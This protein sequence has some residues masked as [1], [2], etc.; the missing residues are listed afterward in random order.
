METTTL[1]PAKER[2]VRVV[3]D[4]HE[5]TKELL[6][7]V[8]SFD[9]PTTRDEEWKYTRVARITNETW[10][11]SHLVEQTD[12]QPFLIPGLDAYTIVFVNGR[13][14]A[15]LCKLPAEQGIHM[16]HES[17]LA[18]QRDSYNHFFQAYADA[19]CTDVVNVLVEK[20]ARI[21]KPIHFIH[22]VSKEQVL[23]QPRINLIAMQGAEV[24]C[25]E[26]FVGNTNTT[27]FTNRTLDIEVQENASVNWDKIQLEHDS[28][29]LMNEDNIRIAGD[30]RFTINTLTIDGGWVRNALNI[31]LDGQNIETN[32]NGFYMPRRKQF[33][34]NHTKVD[35]RHPHCNSNEL[36][37]GVLNDQ[38]TGVFNGKVYVQIDAQKTNAFQSCA[39]ILL[40]DDAQMNTK[41][42]LEIYADDVKCSHGTTTG[43]LDEEALFYLKSRGL[44]E[45]NARR[46]LTSAFIG[47]VISKIENETVREYVTTQL[48]QR[49]LLI[50]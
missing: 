30:G 7:I 45:D 13:Y 39:N 26:S 8:E 21:S 23:S 44:G 41:P 12:V 2:W 10:V 40:S 50:A 1:N 15:T 16:S 32:L 31:S 28:Q 17:S 14:N 34:D 18:K 47:D 35:H 6:D 33:V 36:Y 20:N 9:F 19:A 3:R 42:E 27:S 24:K 46:L 5:C 22:I 29:F 43:Q 48:V 4:G 11:K 37:K 38:S 25:I 49:E